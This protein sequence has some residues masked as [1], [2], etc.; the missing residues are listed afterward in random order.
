VELNKGLETV[1]HLSNGT[2]V[3][4]SHLMGENRYIVQVDHEVTFFRKLIRYIQTMK[5]SVII[6]RCSFS[7]TKR[8]IF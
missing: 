3:S 1:I 2:V 4:Y 8:D 7:Y 5:C 6:I